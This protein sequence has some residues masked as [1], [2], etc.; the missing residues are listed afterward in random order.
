M[1]S[2]PWISL[3][4]MVRIRLALTSL[5]KEKLSN[6]RANKLAVVYVVRYNKNM[7][8]YFTVS[9]SSINVEHLD[10]KEKVE[11][12]TP[13]RYP[14]MLL[15]QVGVDKKHRG[16]GIGADICNFCMGLAQEVGER[17]ACRYIIL[18]TSIGKTSLYEKMGFSIS[19]KPPVNNKIWM[20]RKFV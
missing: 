6:N 16:K 11:H 7:A 19:P 10:R 18:Q 2:V 17:I 4:Q 15:G 1:I 9:M 14:A 3:R 5:Q 12:A 20:Y 8:A 13:I